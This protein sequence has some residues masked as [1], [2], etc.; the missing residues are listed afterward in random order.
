MR[1]FHNLPD[2]LMTPHASGWTG[3]MLNAR[4]MLIPANIRRVAQSE[5][6]LNLVAP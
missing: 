5:M 6:P 4:V 1:P 3:G 2:V